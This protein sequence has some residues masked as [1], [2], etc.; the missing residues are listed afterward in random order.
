MFDTK[1]QMKCSEEPMAD[2]ENSW[3]LFCFLRLFSQVRLLQ[4]VIQNWLVVLLNMSI[5]YSA[6]LHS[7]ILNI[8]D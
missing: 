3:D 7:F 5:V 1:T 4:K 8:V 6:R 2:N